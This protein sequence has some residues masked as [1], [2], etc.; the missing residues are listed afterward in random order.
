ML[1][2][3]MQIEKGDVSEL[4]KDLAYHDA[5]DGSALVK[6]TKTGCQLALFK[7]LHDVPMGYIEGAAFIATL[8][9][10]HALEKSISNIKIK[11]P[12]SIMHNG[13]EL[14]LISLS[15][16]FKAG[17]FAVV[18]IDFT[19]QLND[20]QIDEVVDCV[21]KE[22]DQWRMDVIDKK[23]LAG[24]V[25]QCLSE[26]FDYIPELGLG[27]LVQTPEGKLVYAGV[28][29]GLDVWGHAIVVDDNNNEK[30][31]TPGEVVLICTE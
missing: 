4:V 22:L 10:V 3:I 7:T 8:A 16:G 14:A 1:E 5:K 15:A 20:D 11:W 31:F 26:Y 24:P 21:Y 12:T 13:N 28:F 29:G 2:N 27:T 18:T 19:E 25:S 23:I 30:S 17:L 6:K 9:C